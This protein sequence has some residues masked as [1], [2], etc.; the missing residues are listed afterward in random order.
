MWYVQ[1]SIVQ[2]SRSL[3]RLKILIGLL[4]FTLS[5][6]VDLVDEFQKFV[7]LEFLE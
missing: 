3:T 1:E 5:S 2:R 4:F 7:V 6:A